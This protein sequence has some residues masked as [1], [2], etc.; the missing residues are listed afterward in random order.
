MIKKIDLYILRKF[1]GTFFFSIA[2]IIMIVIVFDIS[3]KIEDFIEKDA[4]FSAIV[5]EYYFNFIPYFVNLFSPLFTFIAVIFFTSRMASRSEIVAILGSG[6]S[7]YRMLYPYFLA[8]VVITV[9][10]LYLNNFVIPNAN[11]R[12]IEFEEKYIRNPFRNQDRN[13][14][15]QIGPGSFIYIERYDNGDNIG[16]KFS[17]EKI[18]DGK[19]YYKMMS[20][21]VQW[22]SVK[23]MWTVNNYFVRYISGMNETVRTGARLD[24]TFNFSPKDFGR[25][26]VNIEMMNYNELNQFIRDEKMKGS[27]SIELYE[28]EKYSRIAFPFATFVLTL[29]G[30]S[31][32]SRKVRGGIGLH[33]GMGSR[34]AGWSRLP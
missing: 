33:I 1:L 8:S 22:D 18:R 30:V 21:F 6:V 7:F 34:K 14:H 31:L 23:Q 25:K 15:R 11:K 17:L 5:F 9:M 28:I 32:A 20:D 13:I 26:L 10:S 27:D 19:L 2:L 4:P 12:R 29:I 3:E 16:Y 24:T